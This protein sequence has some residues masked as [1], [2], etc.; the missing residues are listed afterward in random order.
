LTTARPKP[1]IRR[2]SR[3]ELGATA[4][5]YALIASLVS[6]FIIGAV[7]FTGNGL[8]S[9]YNVIIDAINGVMGN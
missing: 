8:K 1:V 2:F 6:V 3:A 7:S 4:I 9:T 5:E